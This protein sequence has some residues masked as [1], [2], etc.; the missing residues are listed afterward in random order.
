MSRPKRPRSSE[1]PTLTADWLKGPSLPTRR[2]SDGWRA[3]GG[4]NIPN[5]EGTISRPELKKHWAPSEAS[6]HRLLAWL[7]TGVDSGGERYEEMRRRLSAYFDRKNCHAPADLA[8]ETLN[9]IARRLEEEG[10]LVE[11]P[12]ARYCYIVAKFVFLEFT[13]EAKR[14]GPPIDVDTRLVEPARDGPTAE[15]EERRETRL[16]YLDTCLARLSPADRNLILEYY[17]PGAE[18]VAARRQTLATRLGLS[19]NALAIRACRIRAT[20]ERCVRSQ[21]RKP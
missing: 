19:T 6:F 17:G 7:D 3:R 14:G 13:R 8:D 9:R 21:E 4:G 11:G 20:L 16:E 15:D 12:P 18:P 1:P 10:S 2:T 5:R